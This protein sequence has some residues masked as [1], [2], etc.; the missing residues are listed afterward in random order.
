MAC[1]K[2]KWSMAPFVN[3]DYY[4]ALRRYKENLVT[5]KELMHKC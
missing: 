1:T 5:G 4:M 3:M 2:K